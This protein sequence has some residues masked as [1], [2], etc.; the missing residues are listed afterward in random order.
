MENLKNKIREKFATLGWV[1][2]DTIDYWTEES[3]VIVNQGT[4][5]INGQPIQQQGQKATLSKRFEICYD[6]PIKDV[7]TERV[8]ESVMCRWVV[9][10][11]DEEVQY[12]EVNLYPNEYDLF[13]TICNKI[14]GL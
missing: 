8:D 9:Y 14:F 13:E 6:C 5:I 11:D 2:D 4:L 3:E 10:Q 7:A 12:L 1:K